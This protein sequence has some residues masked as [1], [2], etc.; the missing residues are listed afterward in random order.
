MDL[1]VEGGSGPPLPAAPR[2]YSDEPEQSV[3]ALLMA[4][5]LRHGYLP[6]RRA[7]KN[8]FGNIL[9][10]LTFCSLQTRYVAFCQEF[11]DP[12]FI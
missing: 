2:S 9:T 1:F 11:S 8:V 6:G 4:C 10:L 5:A 12:M 7:T 3:R